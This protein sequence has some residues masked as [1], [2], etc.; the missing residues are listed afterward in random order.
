[1][2]WLISGIAQDGL[3]GAYSA[4]L[5]TFVQVSRYTLSA[6]TAYQALCG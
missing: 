4:Y 1:M 3:H 6:G 5:V 2:A